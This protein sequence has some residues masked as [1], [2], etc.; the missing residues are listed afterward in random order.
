MGLKKESTPDSV[1]ELCL[2]GKEPPA[3]FYHKGSDAGSLNDCV[4]LIEIPI[5]DVA[6]LTSP[7][8]SK[9]QLHKLQSA[10]TSWGCFQVINHGMAS[11]FLDRMREVANNFFALPKEEKQKYSREVDSIEGYGNDMIIS[12]KQ[13]LDWTD[14]LYLTLSP[15]RQLK[16][17]PEN[18]QDFR[19][20]LDE[21][22][23]KSQQITEIL[24]KA[25]AMSLGLEENCFLEQYGEDALVTARFNYYP[26]CPKPNQ[27]L[28]VKPHA[29]ASAITILLQDKQVEGLQFLKDDQWFRVPIIP[30]AL[31]VNVG[32]QVE[33]MSN[34]IF[35]SPVHR[36][37][38]NSERER[39]TMAM[40]FIPGSDQ[41]IK[42]A[43][44]LIDERRPR[45]YKNIKDYVSL[46]FQ[47]YQLGRR[48]LEAAMI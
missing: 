24:L 12:E 5:V 29:D 30:H 13:T 28:G 44:A 6:L 46:Y 38:T 47:Y 10:L 25:M 34:G 1:Q 8:T 39:I 32:D 2:S 43:D 15:E 41:E 17:W 40:F 11:S 23:M 20:T 42:P 37:V 7:S 22:F 18:P 27:I 4:P 36:V 26:P 33:I 35:K 48:P 45:L 3:R 31:F 14:R 16:F 9:H 21:F 19:E